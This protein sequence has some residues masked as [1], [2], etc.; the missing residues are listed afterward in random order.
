[1]NNDK[2]FELTGECLG[3]IKKP[4]ME[5]CPLNND[6]TEFIN[7]IKQVSKQK[8]TVEKGLNN[9]KEAVIEKKYK[10][11][12]NILAKTTVL[13][14]ICGRVCPHTKQCQGGCV[15]RFKGNSVQIGELEA[16]IGDMAL[17]NNWKLPTCEK[18][19][20]YKVAVVGG[21]PAGLTCAQFLRRA[22]VQV[23]IYEKYNYLGGIL[24]HGIPDFRLDKNMLKKWI[25][26]I[27]ET[28]IKVKYNMELGKDF[29]IQ[30]LEKEYDAVFLGFGANISSKMGIPGEELEG[31]FGG[32]ELLENNFNLE[33]EGKTVIVSGGGNV[34]MDVSRTAIRK[35][36]K[37][38]YVVY[39]RSEKEMP[40]EQ[41]E[42]EEAKAEGV[43][44]LFQNNILKVIGEK[45]VQAIECIKTELVQ[46]EGDSRLSP[47]NIEG[48]NYTMPCDFVVM[49]IGSKADEKVT[50]ILGV[51][52]D[53]RGKIVVDECGRTSK[54]NIFAGGDI[55]GNMGTVAYAARAGR[56]SAESII[57][58]L[59]N[60][61]L[62]NKEHCK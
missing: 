27:I 4:C 42:I 45:K 11:A 39:R 43:E 18:E 62:E 57:E 9:D 28:G 50:E 34:A 36:A 17:K 60:K 38:V 48:S 35:G 46:K 30:S 22:G 29:T 24:K 61:E 33:Y 3:C 10:E 6:T 23:T 12:F 52:L 37:K 8:E 13:M 53:R 1:M 40:A 21:G 54:E 25:D 7:I 58:Y 55:A 44:F 16:F 19:N 56:N 32:N 41:K 49:A 31:V 2:I 20:N 5:A 15:K 59:N 26:K 51:E 47:V 14:P